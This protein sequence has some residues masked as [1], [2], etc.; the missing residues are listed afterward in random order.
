MEDINFL[1]LILGF[2]V[3]YIIKSFLTFHNTWSASATLVTKISNQALK[4]LGT[5]VY[6]VS[7]M[8]QIYRQAI[9]MA[10]GKETA[11]LCS[12]ELDHEFEIWKKETIKVFQEHYPENYKWQLEIADWEDAMN[13][14]TD[15]YHEEKIKGGYDED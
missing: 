7:F 15:I 3:G 2:F 13:M 10:K 14:L 1:L 6:K 4:L 8:D 9:G 12:N 11:K 5:T